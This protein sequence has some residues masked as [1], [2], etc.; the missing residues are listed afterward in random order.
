M[1]LTADQGLKY[2]TARLGEPRRNGRS[3]MFVCVF[4]ADRNPSLAV[5]VDNP[6]VFCCH[7]CG[8]KG[9]VL[10]FEV[11]FAGLTGKILNFDQ[12]E[13]AICAELGM[14]SPKHDRA[15]AGD[16]GRLEATYRYVEPSGNVRYVVERR[17][18]ENGDKKFI[19]RR[20]DGNGGWIPNMAGVERLLYRLP[21][22]IIANQVI[23]CEGE[24]CVEAVL[25][26]GVQA[27]A[28]VHLAATTS[29]SAKSWNEAFAPYFAGKQVIVLPD[30][31]EPGI[32]HANQVAKSVYPLAEWVKIVN[33]PEL[34]LG[35]DVADYLE[36]H[37]LEQLVE[38]IRNTPYW[39]PPAQPQVEV[40][41]LA[42]EFLRHGDEAI[43]WL[44]DGV[45]QRGSNG[46]FVADPRSGK[47][48]SALDCAIALATGQPWLGFAIPRPVNVAVISREDNPS[49]T[50]WRMRRLL[51]GRNLNPEELGRALWV[52]S[53]AQT[54]QF[55]LDHAD[56][57]AEMLAALRQLKPEL[58]FLDVFN[59]MHGAKENDSGEMR[60]VLT[61]LSE[62]Q[63]EVGCSMALI[64]HFNKASPDEASMVQ[65]IRGSGAIAGWTEWIVGLSVVDQTNWVRKMEFETK[66]AQSQQPIYFRINSVDHYT[67]IERDTEYRP[68]ERGGSRLRAMTTA[69]RA[70]VPVQPQRS[71]H[72]RDAE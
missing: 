36:T 44:V 41:V 8:A 30:N 3:W 60:Q 38:V 64:H 31:D 63:G 54:K 19:Q 65:R 4:H 66:A 59:R 37:T 17:R 2:F 24:K 33:L 6:Q 71:F 11:K 48:W 12:A 15:A 26:T 22:V 14:E 70:P 21:E 62:I 7:G 58:V 49:L 28:K 25:G 43:D 13:E 35:G 20:A 16:I 27:L 46:V 34:G 42:Q 57:M 39:A 10:Q 47:S 40:L 61:S 52:N 32:E 9:N 68:R 56:E 67:R 45:I 1:I 5:P 72:D 23:Y 69:A 18:L 55:M 50:R 53:R 29:G 51:A